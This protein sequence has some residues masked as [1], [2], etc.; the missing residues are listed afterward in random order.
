MNRTIENCKS[1]TWYR[2]AAIAFLW[3][4]SFF[5]CSKNANATHAAGADL[6]Y[7]CLG[8]LVY[9]VECTFYRDCDGSAE[10]NTVTITY[11]SASLGYSRTAIAQ[12]VLVNNGNE[13]TT[14][15]MASLSSCNGGM[16][17]GIRKWVYRAVITLPSATTDWVFSYKVCCRNCTI[18][19]I[20]SPCATS[21]ELYIEA[22]LNNLLAPGNNSPV[23]NNAPV[24]FVCLSQNFNYNQGVF[25]ADGDSLVYE[26]I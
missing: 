13:I 12:K 10:P 3:T 24:A 21:S 15:C 23:F 8:G 4:F 20:Q 5:M 22:T 14:P 26:L 6:T 1:C 7:Q 11:K 17:A 18:S 9:Q 25:D 16:S 19:T 2:V